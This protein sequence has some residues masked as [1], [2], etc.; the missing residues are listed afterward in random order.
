MVLVVLVVG[1]LL[2]ASIMPLAIVN[3]DEY[4]RR[5]NAKSMTRPCH[6]RSPLR[7]FIVFQVSLD[8]RGFIKRA[9]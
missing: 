4:L 6:I 2:W 3:P 7:L 1:A 8:Q 9:L 5:H